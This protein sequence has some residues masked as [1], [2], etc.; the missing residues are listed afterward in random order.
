MSCCLARCSLL[1]CNR[2]Y[3]PQS[4][5][6]LLLLGSS[7]PLTGWLLPA[8]ARFFGDGDAML[9]QDM[10]VVREGV[11]PERL[12]ALVLHSAERYDADRSVDRDVMARQVVDVEAPRGKAK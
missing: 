9:L 3:C 5:L 1:G 12:H 6:R 8:R 7:T 10:D 4:T 11:T 2:W